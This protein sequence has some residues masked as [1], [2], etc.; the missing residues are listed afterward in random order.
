MT[1]DRIKE[2]QMATAYPNSQSVQQA[3]LQVWNECIQESYTKKEV[4]KQTAVE[5][6]KEKTSDMT[7]HKTH[8]NDTISEWQDGY[9][10]ALEE[11]NKLLN[12]ALEMENL[13]DWYCT[14]CGREIKN[15]AT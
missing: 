3:L 8:L 2:I 10:V 4:L 9:N 7:I 5:W 6:L 1:T 13:T 14:N 15:N 12:K 11:V